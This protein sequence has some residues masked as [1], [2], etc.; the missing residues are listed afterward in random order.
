LHRGSRLIIEQ[1]RVNDEVWLPRHVAVDLGF[2]LALLKNFNFELDITDRD[3]KQFRSDTRVIPLGE[4]R[5]Q[6]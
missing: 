3:Y 4:A 2:R 5:P 6:P 1:T